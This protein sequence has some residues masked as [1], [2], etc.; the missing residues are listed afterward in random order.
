[1]VAQAGR[2]PKGEGLMT[3]SP[4]DLLLAWLGERVSADNAAWLK[5]QLDALGGG[6]S[7][8]DLHIALGLTPR[9]LGKADLDL[10]ADDLAA[11]QA[12]RPGWDPS[13][14]SVDQAAR[15]LILATVSDRP[16][17]PERFGE[18]CRTADV[19]EAIAFYR[20]LPLYGGPERL[21][22]QAGEGL[23]T[24]MRAV[25]EA[26]AHRSPYPREQFDDSRWNQ[27]VLKALFIGS[28]LH[29]IQG[30]DARGNPEL[31]GILRDYAHER[32]AAG[33]SISPELWR[34]VGPFA[35]D[36]AL[37]DLERV[38]EK[39]DPLERKAAALALAASPAAE[40]ASSL[41]RHPDLEAAVA[42]GALNWQSLAAELDRSG[43]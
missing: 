38:L 32:W 4:S 20:G 10:S 39:G 40:A 2:L 17:F 21:E 34:C 33:R 14:W 23:R 30:I 41:K 35:G 1:M 19:A 42:S 28:R 31:A 13:A 8:R 7:D 43:A 3:K 12:A 25:F 24:N 9:K 11:A 26:V 15:I 22:W 27:M 6:G 36:E 16:E 29:P 37:A 5:G 18:L